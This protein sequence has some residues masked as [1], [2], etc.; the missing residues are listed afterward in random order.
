MDVNVRLRLGW[1]VVALLCVTFLAQTK[2]F[3]CLL[4]S[5]KPY[6]NRIVVTGAKI[7]FS[8]SPPSDVETLDGGATR[9]SSENIL[10]SHR[11]KKPCFFV[12]LKY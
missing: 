10:L 4:L 6:A 1:V 12:G 5:D 2:L 3:W 8:G 9:R 11:I 7:R